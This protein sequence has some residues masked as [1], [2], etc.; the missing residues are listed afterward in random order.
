MSAHEAETCQATAVRRGLSVYPCEVEPG[1]LLRDRGVLRTVV[2]ADEPADRTR[3]VRI[4]LEPMQGHDA[5]LQVPTGETI[6]VRRACC[7]RAEPGPL[8]QE[9][10]IADRGAGGFEP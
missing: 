1:D 2:Y 10:A 6:Y 4:H 7:D 3:T 9:P 8:G 5:H